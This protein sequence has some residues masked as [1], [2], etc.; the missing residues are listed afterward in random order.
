[1]AGDEIIG[2]RGIGRHAVGGVNRFTAFPRR[3]FL[4]DFEIMAR[5]MTDLSRIKDIMVDKL[6]G[7][8][9]FI[10]NSSEVG[11]SAGK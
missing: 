11:E 2:G 9:G 5:L 10:G 3:W 7:G 4:R 8:G 6:N 1:M